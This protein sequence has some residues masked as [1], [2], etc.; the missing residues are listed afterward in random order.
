MR[1]CP[2]DGSPMERK[3]IQG[4]EVDLS[5]HGVWLD[6]GELYLI[7]EAQRHDEP[8]WMLSDLFRREQRPPVDPSRRLSC[9][10]CGK[11]MEIVKHHDVHIDWC[12]EHGIWLD[13]GELEAIQSNLR[14]DPLFVGKIATRLWETRF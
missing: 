1:T 8:S 2:I 13:D 14:L 9:P 6:K 7:T 12:R 5:E 4:V 10:V 11:Q 3:K